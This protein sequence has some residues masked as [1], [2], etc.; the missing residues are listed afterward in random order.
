M[1]PSD[2][3]PEPL[4]TVLVVDDTITNIQLLISVLEGDCDLRFATSGPDALELLA[5]T[6]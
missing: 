5:S 2:F 3:S 6:W 1:T 4:P